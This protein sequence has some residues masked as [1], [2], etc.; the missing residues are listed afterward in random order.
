MSE[1]NFPYIVGS[2]RERD[3]VPQ[4][5]DSRDLSGHVSSVVE[6]IQCSSDCGTV[7]SCSSSQQSPAVNVEVNRA[8]TRACTNNAT[9]NEEMSESNNEV[10]F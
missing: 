2:S 8:V 5:V 9:E 1:L 6:P 4:R 10:I 7:P 3:Q